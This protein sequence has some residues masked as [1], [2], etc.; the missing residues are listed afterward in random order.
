MKRFF[1]EVKEP[2]THSYS[3]NMV[4]N[5]SLFDIWSFYGFLILEK[6]IAKYQ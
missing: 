3:V 4:I 5:N 1:Y 2:K 6:C